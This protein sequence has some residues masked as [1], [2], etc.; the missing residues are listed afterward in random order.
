MATDDTTQKLWR[1]TFVEPMGRA[2]ARTPVAV[3]AATAKAARA[4]MLA[5]LLPVP[6]FNRDY[7][8]R[9]PNP[10]TMADPAM[11]RH[12]T[13]EIEEVPDGWIKGRRCS[14]RDPS[15]PPRLSWFDFNRAFGYTDVRW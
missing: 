8:L 3:I 15:S 9:Y 11:R 1:L 4:K 13:V 2:V 7:S 10:A 14:C 6:N 5:K 12:Y